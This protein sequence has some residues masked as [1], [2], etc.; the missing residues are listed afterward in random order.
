MP[1]IEFEPLLYVASN[2]WSIK[3][4]KDPLEWDF[5]ATVSYETGCN[6]SRWKPAKKKVVKL[7]PAQQ[8]IQR[9]LEYKRALSSVRHWYKKGLYQSVV[10]GLEPFSDRLSNKFGKLLQD[11]RDQIQKGE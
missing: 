9:D 3:T 6:A 2:A 10:N 5:F 4:G 7:T 11:A 8:E 1:C